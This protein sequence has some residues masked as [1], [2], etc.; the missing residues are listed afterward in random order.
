MIVRS[1]FAITRARSSLHSCSLPINE[2]SGFGIMSGR[3]IWGFPADLRALRRRL[4][5][6]CSRR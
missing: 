2:L 6:A 1:L 4:S 3:A 5:G